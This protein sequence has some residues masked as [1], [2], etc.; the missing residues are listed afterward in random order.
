MYLSWHVQSP[1]L[2]DRI[3]AQ[4]GDNDAIRAQFIARQ[5]MGHLGTSEEIAQL[6]LYLTSDASSYTTGTINIIDGGWSN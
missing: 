3:D 1:S 4:D 5:P 2:D 6:A